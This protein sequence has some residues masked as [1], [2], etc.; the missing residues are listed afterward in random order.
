EC[1][2]QA[3]CYLRDNRVEIFDITSGKPVA[4]TNVPVG[5]DP[6]TVRFR[7]TSEAWVANYMSDSISIV[8]LTTTRVAATVTTSNEPSDIVFAGAPQRAFVSC[9]QPNLIQVYSPSTL[10]VVTNLASHGQRPR[11]MAVRQGGL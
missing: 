1:A 4:L 10:Q 11:Y 5:L 3:I 8:D 7:T 9:A 6:V 2:T